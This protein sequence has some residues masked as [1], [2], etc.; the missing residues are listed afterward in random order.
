MPVESAAV[1]DRTHKSALM[2]CDC[3]TAPIAA[4]V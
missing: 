2:R 3:P 1:I 4:P